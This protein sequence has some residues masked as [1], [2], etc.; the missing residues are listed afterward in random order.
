M[1]AGFHRAFPQGPINPA[2]LAL[3]ALIR[4]GSWTVE[5]VMFRVISPKR[6]CEQGVMQPQ[7]DVRL[8]L[9]TEEAFCF[10]IGNCGK[11]SPMVG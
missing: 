2:Q 1:Q 7:A 8:C 10:A 3:P 11:K 9:E 6:N 5:P 4:P